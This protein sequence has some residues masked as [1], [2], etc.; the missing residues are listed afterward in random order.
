MLSVF[1]GFWTIGG[2]IAVGWFLASRELVPQSAIEVLSRLTFTV[3]TP[4]LLF[5]VISTAS[6][7]SVVG[8]HLVIALVA[9]LV[10]GAVSVLLARRG[11]RGPGEAV[12]GAFAAGYVNAANLGIP[13]AVFVLG[14][15]VYSTPVLLGQLLV[16][17]PIGLAVLDAI[18]PRRE[19]Q[20]RVRSVLASGLNP[21]T[22]A[23][24]LGLAVAASG[25]QVPQGARGPLDLIAG[26]AVPAMLL[27]YG[28]SLRWG[29]A[30]FVG[31]QRREVFTA[32]ALKLVA[33][34]LVA[35]GLALAWGLQGH[36]LLVV[37]VT[38]ALP[39]AQN[40]FLFATIYRRGQ[41]VARDAVFATTMLSLPVI[42]GVV[43][44]LG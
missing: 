7:G 20:G 19:G 8:P 12:I 31:G 36:D 44:L 11:G 35:W 14:D 39:T 26:F 21:L 38:A 33:M 16:L 42:L 23:S 41:V 30:P 1:E 9:A 2:V 22:V 27:A 10:V 15:A 3:A 18:D 4:V 5:T 17:Q 28:M 40:V 43:L 13:I 24:V 6:L 37:V 25:W 32:V 34:P 29:P